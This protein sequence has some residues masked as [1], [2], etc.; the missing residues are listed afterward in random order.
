MID[1]TAFAY[2]Y[3]ERA[4][5]GRSIGCWRWERENNGWRKAMTRRMI[6][7][8]ILLVGPLI[9]GLSQASNRIIET[10]YLVVSDGDNRLSDDRLKSLAAETQTMLE[11][12]LA[13]WSVDSGISQFG[14][15]RVI[16]DAPRRRDYYTSVVDV[17]YRES[18][19]RVR[20]VRV[21]GA[22]R[23]PLEVV[24]KLTQAIFLRDDKMIRNMIGVSTEEQVGNPLSFP[25]CGFRNDDWVLAFLKTK[26]YIPLNELGPDH[27]SW[28]MRMG[29]DGF[30]MVFD[31]ARQSRAYAE[32]GSFG[33]YL[34]R[35]YGIT[36]IKQF[37]DLSGSKTRPWQEVFGVA[38]GELEANWL[39]F[40]QRQRD[41]KTKD[42]NVSTLSNLFEKN[43]NTACLRA[44]RL[45]AGKR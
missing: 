13:F 39:K 32:V 22:E 33:S 19:R 31:R 17:A 44:Q 36:K 42:E 3:S 9:A 2:Y 43:P 7:V 41:E 10:Q 29:G 37:Y 24:H 14:K 30:P 4:A 8:L 5:C 11:R 35:T 20:A 1:N 27:E 26:T 28:G 38:I 15:I 40:L 6:V 21:F 25:G 18:G 12:V 34:I 16:F 45:A 23:E